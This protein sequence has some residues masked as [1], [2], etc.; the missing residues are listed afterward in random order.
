[1]ISQLRFGITPLPAIINLISGISLA[2]IGMASIRI[3]SPLT[4]TMFPKKKDAIVIYFF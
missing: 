3:S 2:I 4:G 1:M